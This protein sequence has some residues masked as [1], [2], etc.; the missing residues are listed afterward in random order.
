MVDMNEPVDSPFRHIALSLSGGG[1][2][3]IGFH[4]GT[5][6]Y[7]S[8]VG[9]LDSVHILS[10]VSGG[11]FIGTS[12]ALSLEDDISFQDLFCDFFEFLP[13]INMI[14]GLLVIFNQRERPVAAGRRDLATGLAELYHESF[15]RYYFSDPTFGAIT[16]GSGSDRQH[17]KEIAFSATEFKTG[18]AFRFQ[19]SQFDCKI[20]NGNVWIDQESANEMR[21][22]DI[23]SASSC[24]PGGFAPLVLPNDFH[25]PATYQWGEQKGKKF[26][27]VTLRSRPENPVR[28]SVALM[29]GGVYDNQGITSVLLA[30]ARR[31]AGAEQDYE[32]T[33]TNEPHAWARWA[34]DLLANYSD[35]DLFIISD[36]PLLKDTFY[37]G[38]QEHD[39]GS[40]KFAE[41]LRTRRLCDLNR[42]ALVMALILVASTGFS[43]LRIL[44]SGQLDRMQQVLSPGLAGNLQLAFEVLLTLI[45]L[46][47]A[48]MIGAVILTFRAQLLRATKALETKIPRLS[49]SLWYYLKNLRISDLWAMLQLRAGSLVAL[50]SEIYMHRIRQLGYSLAFSHEKLSSTILPNEI[51]AVNKPP[52]KTPDLPS[53]C[54]KPSAEVHAVVELSSRMTTKAWFDRITRERL[55][56]EISYDLDK[57]QLEDLVSRDDGTDRTDLDVL[58]A[59]GQITMCYNLIR[60]IHSKKMQQNAK[61]GD[62]SSA[63]FATLFNRACK[64]WNSFQSTPFCFVDERL[65]LGRS[66][67]HE[68][69]IRKNSE[70]HGRPIHLAAW[71]Q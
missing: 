57:E 8:R 40:G 19:K 37:S 30:L 20:G 60:H 36:T 70:E 41:W 35:V 49:H 58:V 39:K 65:S 38:E 32:A 45:P 18:I 22:A 24:I 42:L 11:S 68:A 33:E 3:A 6:D 31:L 1:T 66:A 54:V 61:N 52:E 16:C 53:Q 44:T 34:S 26:D 25:W 62:Q 59:C 9:M 10:T 47:V 4:L 67:S 56:N 29:D 55:K 23:V 15:Y 12:Y 51:Y 27:K 2:R 50:A 21:I 48:G 64:D 71:L 43:L 28:D 14:E 13:K 69:Q 7:L 5:L 46:V 17:L 63:E